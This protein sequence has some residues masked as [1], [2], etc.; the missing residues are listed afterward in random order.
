[1]TF[2]FGAS[3]DDARF[4]HAAEEEARLQARLGEA[5]DRRSRD[6]VD[7]LLMQAERAIA[8]GQLD[9]AIETLGTAGV[10][11][12]SRVRI[13]EL[14]GHAFRERGL[15][16]EREGD[17][18]GATLAFQRA[19]TF[20][21][22][23][24]RTKDALTRVRA[25][26]DLRAARSEEIR[27]LYRLALDALA[28]DELLTARDGF[29]TI[30]ALEPDDTEAATMLRSTEEAI[31]TR[32]LHWTNQASA[33]AKAGALAEA[34][35]ALA[36]A[37]ALDPETPGAERVRALIEATRR[38]RAA[39]MAAATAAARP[40]DTSTPPPAETPLS[41]ERRR[42]IANL[43]R[44]GIDAIE[45]GRT[46]DAIRY[47]QLVWSVDPDFESVAEY[48]KRELLTRGMDAFAAGRLDSAVEDWEAA[49]AVDPSDDR[50]SG[51]LAR[52]YEQIARYEKI[53]GRNRVAT[54]D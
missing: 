20:T 41:P 23:D 11:D 49:L 36:N 50:A 47:W 16:L 2:G 32:A 8:A 19:L 18:T 21:P 28:T 17:L 9:V 4:A 53:V 10:L 12:P 27:R 43:Y 26:S 35:N 7:Q 30:L 38:E 40:A 24:A 44:L 31:R 5:F 54:R 29:R 33:L 6:R 42:E 14:R 34:S 39:R 45:A 3:V 51:Y 37:I 22:N 15:S 52:A 13:A 1:M 25:E 46:D 48:L